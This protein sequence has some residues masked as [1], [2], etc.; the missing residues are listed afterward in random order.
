[1]DDLLKGGSMIFVR[2]GGGAT[3]LWR[4]RSMSLY[5]GLRAM[6][7]LGPWAQTLVGG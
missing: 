2:G 4:A 3:I 7:L 6:L 1:M 5:G